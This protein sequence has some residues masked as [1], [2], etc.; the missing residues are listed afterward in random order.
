MAAAVITGDI[1]AGKSSVSR[2]L[3]RNLQC[4][5]VSADVIAKSMWLR[6]DVKA[7]AVKYLGKDILDSS[8]EID[9]RKIS[10]LVFNDKDNHEFVNSLIHPLVMNEL[11]VFSRKSHDSV[12][13]I[14]LLFETGNYEWPDVIIY[15][16]ADFETRLRRCERQRGWNAEELIRRERFLLPREDKIAMSNYVIKNDKGISELETE[17]MKLGEKLHERR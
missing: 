4:E 8:G 14:P 5:Y 3:A 10:L 2:L 15:V 6:G 12:L 9:I 13:E 16:S 1:G 17:I 7:Q 11:E